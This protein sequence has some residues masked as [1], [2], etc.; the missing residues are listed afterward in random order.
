M[1]Y[2][3]PVST[4]KILKAKKMMDENDASILNFS[5]NKANMK[6]ISPMLTD[7]SRVKKAELKRLNKR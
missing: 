6:P 7:I 5:T 1:K 2:N 3:N 4:Q